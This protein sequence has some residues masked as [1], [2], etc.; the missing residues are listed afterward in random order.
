MH[1]RVLLPGAADEVDSTALYA[2]PQGRHLRVNMVSSVDGAATV[3]GRVGILS[4][5]ADQVL[6]H[7]LRDLSD[8]LLV[9]A[10]TIRAEG[11]AP[12]ARPRLAILSGSL[13]LDLG[14]AIFSDPARRPLLVTTAAAARRLPR[15][16][17]VAD[18]LVYDGPRVDLRW[19]LD[20]LALLGLNHVLSEGGPH[21]L[22]QL[23]ADNLVDELCLAI[24]PVAVGGDG[25]RVVVGQPFAPPRHLL[26]SGACERDGYLFLRYG[27]A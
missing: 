3:G 19:A 17:E 18:L 25:L 24:A 21:V 10:G 2:P 13:D 26:L 16:G 12:L 1:V 22:H 4:R 27:R 7:E 9:G 20:E 8:V 11:Y 23:Y 5:S 15:A 6:L 14:S